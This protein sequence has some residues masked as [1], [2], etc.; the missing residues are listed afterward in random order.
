MSAERLT[1]KKEAR[2]FS[3]YRLPRETVA[4]IKRQAAGKGISEAN[5]IVAWAAGTVRTYATAADV[6]HNLE[7]AQAATY[8]EPAEFKRR[9]AAAGP[10]GQQVHEFNGAE[11]EARQAEPATALPHVRQTPAADQLRRERRGCRP[12]PRP[13]DKK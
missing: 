6:K 8:A 13:G 9:A 4:E 3:A 7:E 12:I 5:V 2:I 10:A 1:P 11:I